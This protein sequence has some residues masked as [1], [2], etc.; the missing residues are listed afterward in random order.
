M[1]AT[2]R[3]PRR[4]PS[5]AWPTTRRAPTWSLFQPAVRPIKAL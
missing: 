1:P 3:P 2:C 5:T 4:Q